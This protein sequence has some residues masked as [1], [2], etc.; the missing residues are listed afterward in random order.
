MIARQILTCHSCQKRFLMRIGVGLAHDQKFVFSCPMCNAVLRGV[1]KLDYKK[2]GGEVISEDFDVMGSATDQAI[3][4]LSAINIYTDIPVHKSIQGK[5]LD[6]GGSAFLGLMRFM[7]A[8]FKD[9]SERVQALHEVRLELFPALRRAANLFAEE[10]WVNLKQSLGEIKIPNYSSDQQSAAT[11]FMHL[12]A[13]I[14]SPISHRGRILC[15]KQEIRKFFDTCNQMNGALLKSIIQQFYD[16]HNFASHRNKIV[17]VS[18]KCLTKF[19]SLVP[20]FAYEHFLPEASAKLDEFQIFRDDFDELKVL[21][22]DIFELSSRTLAYLCPILNLAVRSDALLCRDGK[23]RTI[24]NLL[25]LRSVDREFI[26]EDTTE[27]KS[28]YNRLNR[29]TRNDFGHYSV[30][31]DVRSGCIIDENGDK[32][33]L[34]LFLADFLGAVQMM[35]LLLNIAEIIRESK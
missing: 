8:K 20:A 2:I 26:V 24:T 16:Q 22:V 4:G 31:Y 21:Y 7:G 23:N 11:S 29:H 30:S 33:P 15:Q 34:L 17:D 5:G 6:K 9:Y 27:L 10:Q 14:Y 3:K 32:Q 35:P 1:L 13:I 28:A 19:D 25:K 18:V 12:M